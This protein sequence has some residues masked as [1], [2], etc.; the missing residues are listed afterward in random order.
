MAEAGRGGGGI[1]CEREGGRGPSGAGGADVDIMES[2]RA[3]NGAEPGACGTGITG[4][5]VAVGEVPGGRDT[6]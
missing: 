3:R 4:A 6:W 1:G 2:A 5:T